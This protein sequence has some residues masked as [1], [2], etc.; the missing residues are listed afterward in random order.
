MTSYDSGEPVRPRDGS[1]PAVPRTSAIADAT[2]GD[3][4]LTDTRQAWRI[5][6]SETAS[7][8]LDRDSAAFVHQAL[9]SPCLEVLESV[10]GSRL[11][12][13]DDHTLLDFHG[14]SC[15]NVGYGH[16]RVVAAIAEQLARLPFC[17]RRYTN[18]TAVG[19]AE[20]L[21]A[22]SPQG[23]LSKVLLAPG[24]AEAMSIAMKLAR[25]ATG[26]SGFVSFWNSF[27]GATIDTISIG[28]ERH[29]REHLGPLLPNCHHV[30]PPV[31]GECGQPCG[32]RCTS[33]CVSAIA[34]TLKTNPDIA[35]VIAE[36]I[37]C[38]TVDLAPAGYWRS[39][40]EL[41]DA[42]G[43][44][45]IFDEIPIGLGRTGAMTAA[46]T[47]GVIPDILVLGKALGGGVLPL[48]AML[49]SPELD[50]AKF[51]SLGHFT[52]EKS[53]ILAA[54]G[55][56]T[57]N[58]IESEGLCERSRTLGEGFMTELRDRTRHL[59]IVREIRGRGLLIGVELAPLPQSSDVRLL[60]ERVMYKCLSNGLSFKVSG[61]RV[62][63]LT[64]PLTISTEDLAL[65]MRILIDAL[66]C[67]SSPDQRSLL[68]TPHMSSG[69]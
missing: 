26:K 52:H 29:F 27:H 67:V 7:N 28:G 36:P 14:N 55:L 20:K 8:L 62:L 46:E 59:P 16:P 2:E 53:P 44:L 63:T 41:C 35:A 39:V 32:S 37:R 6:R 30:S 49:C 19:F 31:P 42:H 38:T 65:A 5:A 1:P 3:L 15:H 4:N 54:A 61:G 47:E 11:N 12:T 68:A 13:H 57:L 43:V 66:E 64:P 18:E 56:A 45:L 51:T 50:R 58:V 48:A 69:V 33:A 25:F 9:S 34:E 23:R 60:A 22:C 17:P 21:G 40:R 10:H 24:G